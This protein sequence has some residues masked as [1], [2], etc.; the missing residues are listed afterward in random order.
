M[1]IEKNRY[2]GYQREGVTVEEAVRLMLKAVSER[3]P[4]VEEVNLMEAL[5]R[6]A[7]RDCISLVSQ[8]PFDRSP[9]DGYALRAVDT[10]GASQIV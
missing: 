10:K 7:A 3:K 8:P 2:Q 1:D 5:G 6:V 9:L 4:K